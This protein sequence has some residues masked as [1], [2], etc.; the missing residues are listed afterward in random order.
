MT[1][2]ACV[3]TFCR[4]IVGQINALRARRAKGRV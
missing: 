1:F 3:P 4:G 2:V